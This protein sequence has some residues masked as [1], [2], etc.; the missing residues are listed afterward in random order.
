MR[1]SVAITT[2]IRKALWARSGNRCAICTTQ[3]AL[4]PTSG[5][6]TLVGQ[7]CHI[8]ARSPGGPRAGLPVAD[9]DGIDNLLLLCAT[10]HRLVDDQPEHYTVDRL[11]EIKR[12][13]EAGV[14]AVDLKAAWSSEAQRRA[15]LEA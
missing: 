3:L 8:V 10:C 2:Q 13:H 9:I 6:A 7:E 1:R 15:A 14:E 4:A 5:R 11:R 12:G